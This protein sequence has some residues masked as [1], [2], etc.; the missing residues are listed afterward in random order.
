MTHNDV[1]VEDCKQAIKA[2]R[3]VLESDNAVASNGT[4]SSNA[5]GASNETHAPKAYN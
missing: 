1:S 5:N 3:S 4:N 2:I